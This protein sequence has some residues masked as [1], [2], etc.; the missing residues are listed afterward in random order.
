VL[1]ISGDFQREMP[2][3][4]RRNWSDFLEIVLGVHFRPFD[5]RISPSATSA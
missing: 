2:I 5:D 1:N 3:Q 4:A